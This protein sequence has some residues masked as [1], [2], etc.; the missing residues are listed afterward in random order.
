MD[1]ILLIIEELL[2]DRHIE[3]HKLTAALG[4]KSSSVYSDWISEKNSSYKKRLPEIA[5]FF[6]IS[7]E[8]LIGDFHAEELGETEFAFMKETKDLSPKDKQDVL[9][10]IK[11]LKLKKE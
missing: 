11:Y 9:N 10:Y 5:E 7:I 2:K 3:R 4:Y 1:T 6:N 8:Q